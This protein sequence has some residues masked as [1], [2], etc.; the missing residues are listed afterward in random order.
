MDEIMTGIKKV[1]S[2]GILLKHHYG[3]NSKSIYGCDEILLK[4]LKDRD[5]NVELKPVLIHM[6]GIDLRPY[7]SGFNKSIVESSVYYLTDAAL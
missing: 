3:Y 1:K 4:H 5:L 2:M 7:D 6:S